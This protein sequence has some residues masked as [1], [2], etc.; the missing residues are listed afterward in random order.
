MNPFDSGV[1]QASGFHGVMTK[2]IASKRSR[3]VLSREFP[4]FYNPMWG[5]FGDRTPG[6]PGTH[7]FRD[8]HVSFEW[9]IYSQVLIRPDALPWMDDTI[10]IVDHVGEV[11]LLT[12]Q[13]IPNRN[14]GSD[15]LP[16]VFGLKVPSQEKSHEK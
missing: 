16:L 15:H 5:F 14:V 9:N 8:K 12:K 7:Y 13:G 11:N 10:E 1:V 4:F 6:P 2:A 3:K